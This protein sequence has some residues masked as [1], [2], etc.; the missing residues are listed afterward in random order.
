MIKDKAI[1]NQLKLFE[2]S[3][4]MIWSSQLSPGL[5][6]LF[7]NFIF[8]VLS[9]GVYRFSSFQKRKQH[10]E[11]NILYLRDLILSGGTGS[12]KQQGL[13]QQRATVR[14]ISSPVLIKKTVL[15]SWQTALVCWFALLHHFKE[16]LCVNTDFFK[17]R[18][19]NYSIF[20]KESIA[21][22]FINLVASFAGIFGAQLY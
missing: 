8:R 7:F 4:C 6:L 11:K 19:R 10:V 16:T 9:L 5:F 1:R 14:I 12:H 3:F 20:L 15:A 18:K 22:Y 13:G 2:V 21:S 17:K